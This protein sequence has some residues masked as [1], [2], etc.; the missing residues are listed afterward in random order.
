MYARGNHGFGM[1]TQNLPTDKW[2]DRFGEWMD[3]Q[4]LL[5]LK[6]KNIAAPVNSF[7]SFEKKEF[8]Y[9]DG[10]VLPYRIQ[11]P[12]NY[13]KNKKY[14]LVVFLHGAGERGN[15]NEKQLTHGAKLFAAEENRKNF[16]AIVIFPQ[17]PENSA[18]TYVTV[19]RTKTPLIF[20]FNYDNTITWPLDA[21]QKITTQLMATE[22]IDKSR[23]Y[24]TGLSMG[25]MGTFEM[26]YRFPKIFAAAMPICGGGDAVR[27]DER[28]KKISFWV[29]HGDADPVVNVN[30]SRAMVNK[31]KTI[32]TRVVY[33]EYPAVAHNSWDNAFAEPTFLSWMFSKVRK[34]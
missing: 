17:C 22:S 27:Y 30:E 25:G 19:D 12:V 18:W 32:N 26:V 28:V 3:V 31:L 1:R 34:K 10:K 33:T 4:G 7:S 2:I 8:I 16:P 29:F 21:V 6:P 24:I 23:C 11:Y 5:K 13:D 9:A 20:D 15:D 14:P